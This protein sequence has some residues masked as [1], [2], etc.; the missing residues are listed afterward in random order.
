MQTAERYTPDKLP[1]EAIFALL[2][3]APFGR[4]ATY[5]PPV[6]NGS[7][8][9]RSPRAQSNIAASSAGSSQRP[10]ALSR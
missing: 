1:A 5:A 6:A 10:T 4:L 9:V 7:N 3:G 2:D 8:A